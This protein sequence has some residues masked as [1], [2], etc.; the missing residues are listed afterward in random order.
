MLFV[1]FEHHYYFYNTDLYD[2]Y[3]FIWSIKL[4]L[5]VISGKSTKNGT[6]TYTHQ[7]LFCFIHT[8]S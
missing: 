7:F 6:Y 4:N 1:H 3:T 8:L 5:E 2:Y